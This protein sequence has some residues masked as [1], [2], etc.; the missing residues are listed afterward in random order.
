VREKGNDFCHF[1][2]RPQS[3]F[4]AILMSGA[5]LGAATVQ[6]AFAL[7][8]MP[9]AAVTPD[10]PIAPNGALW[11]PRPRETTAA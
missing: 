9:S 1:Y 5:Q 8:V 3:N 2:Y 11:R 7:T 4:T 10:W 6:L